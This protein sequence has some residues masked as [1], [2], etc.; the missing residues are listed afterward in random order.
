VKLR[1]R[2]LVLVSV[3]LALAVALTTWTVSASARR[4]FTVLDE[5]RRAALVAGFR[6]EFAREGDEVLRAIDRLVASDAVQ[7]MAIELAGPA[8]DTSMYVNEAGAL[9]SAHGLDFLEIVDEDGNIVS[10][11]QWPARFGYRHPWVATTSEADQQRVFLRTVELPTELAL[12]LVGVRTV[13]AGDR[14]LFMVGGRRLDQPFLGALGSTPGSRV[15]LYRNLDPGFAPQQLVDASG[16]VPDA[17]RLEPLI[18]RV[19]LLGRDGVERVEWADGPETFQGIPLAGPNG[20]VLGVLLVGSSGHELAALVAGIRR[21]GLLF[22]ALGV[23]LGVGLSWIIAARVTRPIEELASGARAVADG[24]WNV[25]VDVPATG[26][27]RELA[28]AFNTMTAELVD[29]RERLVQAERVAAWREIARRLAHELKNPLFPLRITVE[30]LQRAKAQAPGQF[31]E[32]FEESTR[33]LIAELNNLNGI[34]G[35]FGDFAKMPAPHLEDVALNALVTDTLKLFD[36]Q[37]T[38]PGRPPLAARVDLDERV[39]A[40]RADPEQLGRALRNLLLNAIDAM[41]A[42]GTITVRTTAIDG[43]VRLQVA[44]TGQGLTPEEASRLFTPYYTTKQHGTGLGLAIVQ[45]VV[46]DH[47]GKISVESA[48]GRGTTFSIE[49]PAWGPQRG[50]RAGG[51]A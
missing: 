18:S 50:S 36:A 40:I 23:A 5:Q 24:D 31:D 39:V 1:Y 25:R 51:P 48:A 43:A 17:Q 8:P 45:S 20:T 32:V 28:D 34:I 6:R 42:G 26:D 19:R 9:A 21:A 33:T 30:N 38:A 49:L 2:L 44:D 4:A 37:L 46:S 22:G 3:T 13:A 16:K 15:L 27:V 12:A 7:R 11:A 29:Q 47:H 14:R 10:S 35:R 41:P